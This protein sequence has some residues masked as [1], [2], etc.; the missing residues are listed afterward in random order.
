M[1]M[2]R[3]VRSTL[4]K[5]WERIGISGVTGVLRMR[6]I[7]QLTTRRL[8]NVPLQVGIRPEAEIYPTPV[9]VIK[10]AALLREQQYGQFAE[11][12]IILGYCVHP[13]AQLR[14]KAL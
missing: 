1:E 12:Y 5:C 10:T 11:L 6:L 4:L 3:D 7:Q 8:C 9:P 2:V 13:W 14:A